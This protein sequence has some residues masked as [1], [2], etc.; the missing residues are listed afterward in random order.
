MTLRRGLQ[1][2]VAEIL[3]DQAQALGAVSVAGALT[4]VGQTLVSDGTTGAPGLAFSGAPSSGMFR[5]GSGNP[6]LSRAGSNLMSV[7]STGVSMG[8]EL[9][10]GAGDILLYERTA[11]AAPPAN[12]VRVFA[13]DSGGGK[14]QLAA[15]FNTGAVQTPAAEP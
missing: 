2:R 7:V 13:Q 15:R 9:T 14:T 1:R 4:V 8:A 3:V 12:Q 11:P 6:S 10:I 5:D